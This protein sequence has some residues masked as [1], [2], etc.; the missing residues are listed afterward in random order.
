V[1]TLL[2]S[3]LRGRSIPANVPNSHHAMYRH[4]QRLLNLLQGESGSTVTGGGG[5]V[6]ARYVAP[7]IVRDVQ[8]SSKLMQVNPRFTQVIDFIRTYF[9][10]YAI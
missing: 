9:I 5:D 7:T 4:T 1:Q 6:T 10:A 3:C 8:F 2:E